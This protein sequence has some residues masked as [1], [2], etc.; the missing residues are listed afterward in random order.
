MNGRL[1]AVVFATL[2]GTPA[3]GAELTTAVGEPLQ[4]LQE[5]RYQRNARSAW[6]YGGLGAVDLS[7]GGVTALSLDMPATGL[8]GVGA[9]LLQGIVAGYELDITRRRSASWERNWAYVPS[10]SDE[11]ALGLAEEARLQCERQARGNALAV[12]LHLG[13]GAA[14]AV[15]AVTSEDPD[16]R[17]AGY[18]GIGWAVAGAVHHGARWRASVRYATDLH[19]LRARVPTQV[20]GVR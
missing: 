11:R 9:G 16:W 15:L 6:A 18:V 2:V 7:A 3:R 14:G 8:A 20:P 1:A 17:G 13:L 4:A 10:T 19:L 5:S 12:G